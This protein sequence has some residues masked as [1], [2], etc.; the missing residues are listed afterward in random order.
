MKT[1]YEKWIEANHKLNKCF[2]SVSSDKF[3]KLA[4]AEAEVLCQPEKLAVAAFL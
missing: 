4:A 3:K 2:E 1:T